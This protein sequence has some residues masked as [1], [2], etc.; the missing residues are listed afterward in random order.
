MRDPLAGI[1]AGRADAERGLRG[2]VMPQSIRTR[3]MILEPF[4]MHHLHGFT[5]FFG[6]ADSTRHIGGVADRAGTLDRMARFSGLWR[7]Y[8]MGCYALTDERG[9]LYGYAGIWFPHDWPEP[10]IAYGLL[11]DARGDGRAAEAVRA[12]KSI[13]EA[14]GIPS[15]IST[16]APENAGSQR[17][18]Q[19]VG[20]TRGRRVEINGA[21][22]DIW[23]HQM[24]PAAADRD[25][26]VMLDSSVMPLRIR[27]R[28]LL[29][30]Q[31]RPDH[32]PRLA[33]HLADAQSMRFLGGPQSLHTASRS[34]IQRAGMWHLRGYGMYAVE[35]EGRFIG[36]VG[37]WHPLN[38]PCPEIGYSLTADARGEG[39]AAE[40]VAA[41]REV[42]AE[43]GL[44]RLVSFIDPDNAASQ[45]VARRVGAVLDGTT[46]I[47]GNTVQVWRHQPEAAAGRPRIHELEPAL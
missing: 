39:F 16:I 45:G 25:E 9:R 14:V 1:P 17:V 22:A 27:T 38:W 10:E 30:T 6:D 32:F 13:A 21:A 35:H 20:A 34:F 41:V 8:G 23:H 33:A 24:S 44:S 47:A 18:A 11:P 2:I 4:A 5:E 31:W 29:L 40:A 15:L 3:R 43:Q 37:L 46:S 19:A 26:E 12:V 42:A 28:R 36:S 7:I